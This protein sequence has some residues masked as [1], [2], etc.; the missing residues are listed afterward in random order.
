MSTTSKLSLHPD[1]R[2]PQMG[3]T[4]DGTMST[5]SS[6]TSQ[7]QH[8]NIFHPEQPDSSGRLIKHSAPQASRGFSSQP[9]EQRDSSAVPNTQFPS[10]EE[11]FNFLFSFTRVQLRSAAKIWR[12]PVGG[13]KLALVRRIFAFFMFQKERDITFYDCLETNQVLKVFAKFFEDKPRKLLWIDPPRG[14]NLAN[15]LNADYDRALYGKSNNVTNPKV[16]NPRKFPFKRR[17]ERLQNRFRFPS[18]HAWFS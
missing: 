1:T 8:P 17:R 6:Q 9:E 18:L 10:T 4:N 11:L 13:N 7:P 2:V 5:P 12:K 3:A 14:D 16:P 15:L